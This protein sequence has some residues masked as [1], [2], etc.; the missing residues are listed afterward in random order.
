MGL[1]A[2]SGEELAPQVVAASFTSVSNGNGIMIM[3]L[4]NATVGGTFSG[5]AELQRS[6]DGGTTY[7]PCGIDAAGD[8]A[9]YTSPVSLTVNEP[10]PGVFYRWA[11][12]AFVS[13]TIVTRISG[14]PRLT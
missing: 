13:G 11:C 10:E 2:P 4:F 14:G 12:T 9:D 3:G 1:N 5:T 6:F 7:I 8:K